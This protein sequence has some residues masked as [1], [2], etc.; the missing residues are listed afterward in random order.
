MSYMH[1]TLLME[2]FSLNSG[3][4]VKKINEAKFKY[5]ALSFKLFNVVI[6]VVWNYEFGSRV[7]ITISIYDE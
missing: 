1:K 2:Y 5:H 4:K 3:W 6:W 7:K